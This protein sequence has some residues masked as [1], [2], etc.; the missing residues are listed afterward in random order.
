MKI[1]LTVKEVYGTAFHIGHGIFMT[2]GHVLKGA[3]AHDFFQIGF[4]E[5][6]FWK[7]TYIKSHEL[8]EDYDLA[9]FTTDMK[10]INTLKWCV[11]EIPMLTPIYSFG[12]PFALDLEN[13]T[14]HVRA[15][16]SEV[17]SYRTWTGL[18]SKPRT[19]ELAFQC[20]KGLSGAP[21][22]TYPSPPKVAGVIF[23]NSITEMNVYSM[24][25]RTVEGTETIYEKTEAMH[26]GLAL[27]SSS[28]LGI[29]STILGMSFEEYLTKNDLIG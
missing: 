5:N 11:E 20:P 26:L 10:G 2:A 7:A 4:P 9:F 16:R 15:F 28:I 17:V 18:K 19:L 8:F 6:K 25:E 27:H 12:F 22:L 29:K 23:G 1:W 14:I 21:I 24:T 3:M 13:S